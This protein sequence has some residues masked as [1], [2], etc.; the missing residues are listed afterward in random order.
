MFAMPLANLQMSS[1]PVR[2]A[3]SLG[4]MLLLLVLASIA[5]QGLSSTFS[6]SIHRCFCHRLIY[7]VWMSRIIRKLPTLH[8]PFSLVQELALRHNCAKIEPKRLHGKSASSPGFLQ[9][10]HIKH[11]WLKSSQC[12]LASINLSLTP[13]IQLNSSKSV[14]LT[15]RPWPTCVPPASTPQTVEPW[16]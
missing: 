12:S 6:W 1:W 10:F 11:S 15:P 8:C 5:L 7:D 4:P 16:L 3:A 2:C 13:L 9:F 14:P